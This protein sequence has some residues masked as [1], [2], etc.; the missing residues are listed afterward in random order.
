MINI[1]PSIVYAPN[2]FRPNSNITENKT[3]MPVGAGVDPARFN[4]KIFNRWGEMVFET[5]SLY[6]PWDGTLKNGKEAPQGN[7]V[8]ISKYTDIQGIERN[9]KGQVLLLR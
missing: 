9:E 4:L 7:Y 3:F 2:A 6:T 8:W 1:I 5:S